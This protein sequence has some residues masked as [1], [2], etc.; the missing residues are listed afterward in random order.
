MK[1]E[2]RR[3]EGRMERLKEGKKEGSG[4]LGFPF[5]KKNEKQ[6]ADRVELETP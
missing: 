2:K 6:K 3:G 4:G 5:E 1:E